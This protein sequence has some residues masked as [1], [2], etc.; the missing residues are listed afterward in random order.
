LHSQDFAHN[1]LPFTLSSPLFSVIALKK[2]SFNKYLLD[3][4]CVQI[5]IKGHAIQLI[6]ARSFSAMGYP[7]I[8]WKLTK[9]LTFD[10]SSSAG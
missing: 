10:P 1:S 5:T 4:F 2:S 9:S 6:L 3:K 8:L 7:F